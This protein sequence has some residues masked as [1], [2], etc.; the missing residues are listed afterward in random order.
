M[1]ATSLICLS[2]AAVCVAA[3]GLAIHANTPRA[4]PNLVGTWSGSYSYASA[5]GVQK[6]NLQLIIQKQDGSL[7]SGL[8]AWDV[9]EGSKPN[10]QNSTPIY[11][12]IAWDGHTADAAENGGFY[13]LTM[14]SENEMEATFLRTNQ[15]VSAFRVTLRKR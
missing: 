11:G 5:N 1:N 7:I 12:V 4:T 9:H 6:A 8:D 13:R 3:A 2:S 15:F 14:T 10:R